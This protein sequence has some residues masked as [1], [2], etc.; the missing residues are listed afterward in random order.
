VDLD[1]MLAAVDEAVEPQDRVL[2]LGCGA[3]RYTGRLAGRAASV[4]AFDP[5]PEGIERAMDRHMG[6]PRLTFV[7]GDT[8]DLGELGPD[9]VDL[10]VA[11]GLFRRLTSAK[12]VLGYVEA[13]GRLLAPGGRAV[14]ALSTDPTAGE[15]RASRRDLLR[16]LS[17]RPERPA[18]AFVPLDALGAVAVQA[19]LTLERIEGAGTRDSVALARR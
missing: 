13:A 16:G 18:G 5:S 11:H 8:E 7:Q 17:R 1:A 10:V 12:A 19:G 4:V 2:E 9:A 6:V 14:L 3:G 15:Q